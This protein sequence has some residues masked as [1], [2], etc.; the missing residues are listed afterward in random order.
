MSATMRQIAARPLNGMPNAACGPRPG[1]G[2]AVPDRQLAR[3]H[4][5]EVRYGRHEPTHETSRFPAQIDLLGPRRRRRCITALGNLKLVEAAVR[6]YG[7]EAFDDYKAL[8]CVFLFGG[9]D[10]AQ[11]GGA[12]PT[13]RTTTQYAAARATLALPQRAAATACAACR[14]RRLGRRA[15]TDCSQPST[16]T[17]QWACAACR[18]CSTPAR[19]RCWPTSARWCSR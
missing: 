3:I 11:H 13:P 7:A 8:V 6:A 9:N 1:A 4:R 18:A 15:A 19:P 10:A 16:A 5:A 14:R 17:I 2:S 12:A